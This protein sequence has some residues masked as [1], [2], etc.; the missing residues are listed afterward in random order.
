MRRKDREM[1]KEFALEVIDK[2]RYA[3]LATVSGGGSPYCV[4]LSIAPKGRVYIFPLRF[5]R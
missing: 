1:S 3:T 2:C 4:P 5:G